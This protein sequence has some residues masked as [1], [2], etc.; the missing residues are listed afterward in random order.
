MLSR[1][2][3][4]EAA[5]ELPAVG[6]TPANGVNA[7]PVLGAPSSL[8]CAATEVTSTPLVSAAVWGVGRVP[9]SADSGRTDVPPPPAVEDTGCVD[10][11]SVPPNTG[12]PVELPSEASKGGS[13]LIGAGPVLLP[14]TNAVALLDGCSAVAR[15]AGA[16]A[17]RQYERLISLDETT[18]EVMM[19]ALPTLHVRGR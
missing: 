17:A 5:L 2:A 4:G 10:V 8:G 3:A 1:T 13:P 7:T 12:K 19:P 11:G 9:T 16:S 14:C 6:G 18:H 15:A